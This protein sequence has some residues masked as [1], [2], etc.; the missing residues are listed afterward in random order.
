MMEAHYMLFVFERIMTDPVSNIFFFL[1]CGKL[2]CKWF[3]SQIK[4]LFSFSTLWSTFL[5]LKWS[6][7]MILGLRPRIMTSLHFRFRN[8]DQSVSNENNW[9]LFVWHSH[10]K[11]LGIFLYWI[12]SYKTAEIINQTPLFL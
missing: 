6:S 3:R 10:A 1:N 2:A 4:P 9:V 12:M 8:V 5:N 11:F 7:V